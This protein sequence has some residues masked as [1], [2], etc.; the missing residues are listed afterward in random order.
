MLSLRWND[1][2]CWL[3]LDNSIRGR[4]GQA[5]STSD[6]GP[7]PPYSSRRL[8]R[9]GD[10]NTRHLHLRHTCTSACHVFCGVYQGRP[11]STQKL[12]MSTSTS[13]GSTSIVTRPTLEGSALVQDN[14]QTTYVDPVLDQTLPGG[15]QNYCPSR[16]PQMGNLSESATGGVRGNKPQ[17]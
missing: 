12:N 5:S 14:L 13:S 1:S 8:R 2:G 17:R 7:C 10:A 6:M 4:I 3:R 16:D 11:T 15:V 9:R